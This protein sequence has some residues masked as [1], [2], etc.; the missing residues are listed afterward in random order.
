MN[1]HILGLSYVETTQGHRVSTIK[2]ASQ[3]DIFLYSIIG[4]QTLFDIMLNC[5]IGY[6][7]KVAV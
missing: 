3:Y 5:Y 4:I 2:I 6:N 7:I 1:I